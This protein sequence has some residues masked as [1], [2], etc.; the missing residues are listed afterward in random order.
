MIDDHLLSDHVFKLNKC[1][2]TRHRQANCH[3]TKTKIYS[4]AKCANLSPLSY[5]TPKT[6]FKDSSADFSCAN[7]PPSVH[8]C[9]RSLPVFVVTP[10]RRALRA[11]RGI[12][13]WATACRACHRF[14][15][16]QGFEGVDVKKPFIKMSS[17]WRV[18]RIL[19]L[20]VNPCLSICPHQLDN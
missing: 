7:V 9:L 16:S 12:G 17:N 10:G 3:C 19:T 5:L 20:L 4:N 15:T 13:R 2:H 8:L 11:E 14:L 18:Q 1:H 6:T